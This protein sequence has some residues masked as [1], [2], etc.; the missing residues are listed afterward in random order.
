MK[1]LV[2]EEYNGFEFTDT[3][4]PEI[5]PHGPRGR[6]RRRGSSEGRRTVALFAAIYRPSREGRPFQF[7]LR[8][9][10]WQQPGDQEDQKDSR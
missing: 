1:A 9:G 7:P 2:L 8:P 10:D 6:R 5:G 4:A 3:P